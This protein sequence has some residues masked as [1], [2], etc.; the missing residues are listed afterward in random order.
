MHTCFKC[1]SAFNKQGKIN[2]GNALSELQRNS[3]SSARDMCFTSNEEIHCQYMQ[4]AE[5]DDVYPKHL[6]VAKMEYM[7]KKLL[8]HL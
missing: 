8:F 7:W 4:V 5:Q 2:W 1:I 6:F 3:S